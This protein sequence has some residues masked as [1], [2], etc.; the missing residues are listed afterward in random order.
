MPKA[1]LCQ[2]ALA[3][4]SLAS[5]VWS[6]GARVQSKSP[7]GNGPAI[8]A[9][10]PAKTLSAISTLGAERSS[11]CRTDLSRRALFLLW[12][13]KTAKILGK[14]ALITCALL[15]SSSLILSGERPAMLSTSPEL[16]AFISSFSE[17]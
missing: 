2:P 14:G 3:R 16:N 10:K 9:A 17:E 11:A 6:A 4:I 1:F 7:A 5:P 12:L 15:V 13:R 8:G